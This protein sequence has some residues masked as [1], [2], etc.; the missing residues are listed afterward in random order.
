MSKEIYNKLLHDNI[1]KTCKK[2]D[3]S[4]KDK[5][6]KEAANIAKSFIFKTE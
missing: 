3:S 5:I 2:T 6:D 4:M 1:T